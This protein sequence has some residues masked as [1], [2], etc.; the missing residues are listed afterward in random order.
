MKRTLRI[1]VIRYSRRS[2]VIT[3][4]SDLETPPMEADADI[5]EFFEILSSVDVQKLC[6]LELPNAEGTPFE[7]RAGLLSLLK[8]LI[9]RE[10]H[11][12]SK[13]SSTEFKSQ[14]EV[15]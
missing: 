6:S 11:P 8:Q 15:K 7:S 13:D 14:R 4:G 9:Q 5:H 1:E 12:K 10:K 3:D 2:A